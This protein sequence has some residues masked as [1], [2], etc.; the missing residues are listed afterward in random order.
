MAKTTTYIYSRRMTKTWGVKT[1]TMN[2]FAVEAL[3]LAPYWGHNVPIKGRNS[4]EKQ[5][6]EA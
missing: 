3:D 6:K 4:G 2:S 1:V 5:G